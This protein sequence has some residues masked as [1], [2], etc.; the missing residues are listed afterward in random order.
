MLACNA[1]KV[2]DLVKCEGSHSPQGILEGAPLV[3]QDLKEDNMLLLG[4][5]LRQGCGHTRS[6]LQNAEAFVRFGCL[7]NSQAA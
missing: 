6:G 3:P 7:C 5:A 2:A 4:F 1:C